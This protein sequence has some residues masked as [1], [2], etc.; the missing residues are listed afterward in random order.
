MIVVDLIQRVLYPSTALEGIILSLI[1]SSIILPI[2]W[3]TYGQRY[4]FTSKE[5]LLTFIL[6]FLF[7]ITGTVIA[8][9]VVP[10][11]VWGL[12]AYHFMVDKKY[13]ELPD[14]VTLLIAII[15][16]VPLI[17][18]WDTLSLLNNG[19][20]TGII[21]FAIFLALAF[22]GPMG[23]GDI[24]L[25]GAIGLYFSLYDISTLVFF[26]FLI[27][28]IQGIVLVIIHKQKKDAI[29]AFGPALILGILITTCL[30]GGMF[31]V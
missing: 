23:G 11:I 6:S 3:K 25:M 16:L 29:F 28:S 26:G 13:M 12:L 19:V 7:M 2:L 18:F 20:I 14:G 9:E 17:M 8:D 31:Y 10:I 27:G 5:K 1:F 4:S 15:S 30:K 22:M 21:L 24:K